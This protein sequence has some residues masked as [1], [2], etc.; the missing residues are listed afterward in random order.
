MSRYNIHIDPNLPDPDAVKGREDFDALFKEY[1]AVKRFDFW[2]NLYKDPKV[3][4]GL[5]AAFAIIFLVFQSVEDTELEQ[6]Y[7]RMGAPV[8]TELV[9][10]QVWTLSGGQDTTLYLTERLSLF[11][12]AGSLQDSSGSTISGTYELSFRQLDQLAEQFITGTEH[13]EQPFSLLATSQG[14]SLLISEGVELFVRNDHSPLIQYEEENWLA[15]AEIPGQESGDVASVQRPELPV[16][17][18][19]DSDEGQKAIGPAPQRPGK[20]FGVKVRNINDYPQFRG[21]ENVYW[22]YI[23][24]QGHAD[25]WADGLINDTLSQVRI[26]PY[27]DDTYELLFTSPTSSGGITRKIVVARP[28]LAAQNEAVAL[29]MYQ[30]RMEEYRTELRTW[31]TEKEEIRIHEAQLANARLQYQEAMNQWLASQTNPDTATIIPHSKYQIKQFGHLGF[32]PKKLNTTDSLEVTIF[33]AT[34]NAPE[35]EDLVRVFIANPDN[36]IILRGAKANAGWKLP[37]AGPGS[38]IWAYGHKHIW[39]G[40]VMTTE[41]KAQEVTLTL[42]PDHLETTEDIIRHLAGVL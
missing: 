18:R 13:A 8:T 11:I 25:P 32:A 9:P 41:E 26:R 15:L 17:L 29:S 7:H 4:A 36:G 23:P 34:E 37:Q 38:V 27:R 42:L 33:L 21:Y 28:F 2:R 30:D 40:K 35:A 20:P 16:I 19:N 24:F 12:P 6:A 10:E 39:I 5:A 3:F 31:E 22:E 14:N 1:R